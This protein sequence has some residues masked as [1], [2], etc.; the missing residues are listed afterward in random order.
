MGHDNPIETRDEES[1]VDAL[2]DLTAD[3]DD[4]VVGHGGS[5]WGGFVGR[6]GSDWG[7]FVGRGVSDWGG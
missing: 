5:D 1:R 3:E 7:G 2:D 6:G 4:D